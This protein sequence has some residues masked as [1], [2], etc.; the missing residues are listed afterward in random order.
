MQTTPTRTGHP[1]AVGDLPA[2]RASFLRHLRATNLAPNTVRTYE[3]AV[4]QLTKFIDSR[5][6]PTS[7]NGVKREHLEAFVEDQLAR[8]RP[9]TAAN[10]YRGVQRFFAWLVEEGELKRS[11]LERMKPPR[12]PDQP[13]PVL[14][15][16][17]LKRL[18]ATCERQQGF[19]DR[20]D[21]AILRIFIDCGARL[22][23]VAG[24]RWEPEDDERNDVDL[25]QGQLRFMGK[26]RRERLVPVG[27]RS[28]RALDRYL[29]LR[30]KHREAYSPWLW[31]GRKGRLTDSG[32]A[33]MVR[34][35][36]RQA[37]VAADIHPHLFRH[38]FAHQWRLRGGDGTDLMR[39][40]GWRSPQMLSR[41]GA[42]AETERAL[43][44]HKD[45]G[46]LRR[47]RPR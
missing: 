38:T 1:T 19:D 10:R 27:N 7:V 42:S 30:S 29:R 22:S 5:G 39:L 23:E 41:Y 6:M 34:E 15:D 35:R 33:Q 26:G 36:G 3:D 8:W 46:G 28:V 13:P 32:I 17:D 21:A 16:D 9:A 24:L 43:A 18:L 4:E 44:A 14:R 25:D 45:A 31:L 11:P 40:A 12:V 37:G 47:P 20:R 2:L